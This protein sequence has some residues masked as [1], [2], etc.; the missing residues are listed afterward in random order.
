MD[1]GAVLLLVA[2]LL[3]VGLYLSAPLFGRTRRPV[4]QETLETSS[5]LAERDRVIAALQELDFD[6]KL[7]KVPAEDYPVQRASLLEKGADI[8][9]KLDALLPATRAA[10][11]GQLDPGARIERA[12]AAGRPDGGSSEDLLADDRIESMLSARRAARRA[13][14]AGF[15]PNCGKPSLITDEFCS[16]CGKRLKPA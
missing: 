10:P 3:V 4:A 9:R 13:T 5:L 1:L 7:G 12:A 16:H 11:A 8:L 14:S 2:L 15:C 6:F